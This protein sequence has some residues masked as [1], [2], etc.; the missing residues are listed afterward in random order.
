M[1]F[2]HAKSRKRVKKMKKQ[3]RPYSRDN[4]IPIK[5]RV[6]STKRNQLNNNRIEEQRHEKTLPTKNHYDESW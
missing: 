1:N 4:T 6:E 2:D 5:L 3:L